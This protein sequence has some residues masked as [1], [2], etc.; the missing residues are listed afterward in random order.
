MVPRIARIAVQLNPANAAHPPLL[1][2]QVAA[3]RSGRQVLPVAA[4]NPEDLERA[5]CLEKSLKSTGKTDWLIHLESTNQPVNS[6]IWA[7]MNADG[8]EIAWRTCMISPI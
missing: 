8:P 1:S 3:Q 5:L 7:P 4:G 2:V 6:V